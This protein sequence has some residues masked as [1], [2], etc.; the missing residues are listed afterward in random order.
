M[1]SG[2]LRLVNIKTGK[3]VHEFEK[4][5][6]SEIVV[7]VQSPAVDIIAVGLKNGHIALHNIK[8]DETIQS[9]KQDGAVTSIA[10]RLY[11]CF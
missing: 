3:L 8:F 7:L 11:I 1:N 10:F 6:G 2:A 9:Y 5:F 4:S